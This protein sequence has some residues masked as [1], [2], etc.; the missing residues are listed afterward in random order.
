[1]ETLSPAEIERLN[2]LWR[3]VQSRVE[4]SNDELVNPHVSVSNFEPVN[5]EPQANTQNLASAVSNGSDYACFQS[6]CQNINV[7]LQEAI[8]QEQLLEMQYACMATWSPERRGT[9][10]F[11]TLKLRQRALVRRLTSA[12]YLLTQQRVEFVKKTPCK[13]TD[14]WL[15]NIRELFFAEAQAAENYKNMSAASTD[16]C[17]R[18]LLEKANNA[19]R[20]AAES[21]IALLE[22]VLAVE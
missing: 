10:L 7:Q 16:P 9:R 12:C 4:N 6:S 15:T 2:Q 21:L 22:D 5:A 14:D 8:K 11:N 3:N 13:P 1:M 19:K 17:L 18:D 20:E